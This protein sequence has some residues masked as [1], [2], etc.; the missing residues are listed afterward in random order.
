MSQLN[1]YVSGE[2]EERI[3]QEAKRKGK[4]IS[5]FLA[6]LI[7]SHFA[8]N[9]EEKHFQKFYGKWQGEFPQAKDLPPKPTE[10]F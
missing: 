3:R 7:K 1:F 9:P 6:D 2:I 4:T 5:S 10:E 8:K